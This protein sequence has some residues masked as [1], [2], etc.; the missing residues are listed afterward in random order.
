MMNLE[1]FE[2]GENVMKS[3]YSIATRT[4][5]GLMQS[6]AFRSDDVRLRSAREV[7]DRVIGKPTQKIIM[8]DRVDDEAEKLRKLFK[9]LT[10]KKDGRVKPVAK[11]TKKRAKNRGRTSRPVSARKQAGR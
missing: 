4:I 8:D 1:A 6:K 7:L 9:D 11:D 10:T 3:A 5:I 2:E